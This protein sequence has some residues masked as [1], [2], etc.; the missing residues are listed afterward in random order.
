MKKTT[1]LGYLGS[2]FS[3]MEQ[4]STSTSQYTKTARHKK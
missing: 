2:S 1:T 3:V 4:Q